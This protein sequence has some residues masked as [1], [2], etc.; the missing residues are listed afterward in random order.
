MQKYLHDITVN[1]L[2]IVLDSPLAQVVKVL[3]QSLACATT[4]LFFLIN[5]GKLCQI[6]IRPYIE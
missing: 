5:Q 4:L 6:N 3:R 2:A 1:F